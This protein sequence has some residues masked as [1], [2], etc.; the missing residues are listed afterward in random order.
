VVERELAQDGLTPRCELD[1]DLPTIDAGPVPADEPAPGEAVDQLT[2]AMRL[3]LEPLGQLA[4]RRRPVLG[5]PLHGQQ[6]L[7]LTGLQSGGPRGL[8]AKAEKATDLVA[9][10]RQRPVGARRHRPRWHPRGEF[11]S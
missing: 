11:I 9:E 7:V 1:E 8:L 2:G 10:L 6:E 3:D 5:Q 4:D